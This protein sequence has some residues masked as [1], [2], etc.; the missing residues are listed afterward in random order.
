M[1]EELMEIHDPVRRKPQYHKELPE[2]KV[3]I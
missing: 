1:F 2:Q 3:A